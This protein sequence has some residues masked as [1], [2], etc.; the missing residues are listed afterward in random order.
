[1][2]DALHWKTSPVVQAGLMA[3]S[4]QKRPALPLQVQ[5]EAAQARWNG[6]K[7]SSASAFQV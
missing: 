1:L 4:P 2:P 6:C 3:E 7:Q 5:E